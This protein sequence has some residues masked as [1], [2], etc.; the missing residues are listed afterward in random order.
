M[1]RFYDMPAGAQ[2]AWIARELANNRRTI[3]RSKPLAQSHHS[4]KARMLHE[5]GVAQARRMMADRRQVLATIPAPD[6][7]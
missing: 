2:R 3:A 6:L 5:Y 1:T 4:A 7:P